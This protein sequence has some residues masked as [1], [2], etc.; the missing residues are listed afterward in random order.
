MEPIRSRGY[1][2]TVGFNP[3]QAP[4]TAEQQ[5]RQD[6]EFIRRFK[7]VKQA[8]LD[9]LA[10]EAADMKFRGQ[11]TLQSLQNA[12]NREAQY[13]AERDALQREKLARQAEFEK[14][15]TGTTSSSSK[16]NDALELVGNLSK[17]AAQTYGKVDQIQTEY[18][19]NEADL[20]YQQAEAYGYK[21]EEVLSY[22]N[23]KVGS[24]AQDNANQLIQLQQESGLRQIEATNPA[25]A[26]K[27][28]KSMGN[29]RIKAELRKAYG[30]RLGKDFSSIVSNQIQE[31]YAR[32]PEKLYSYQGEEVAI[33][34]LNINDP[35]VMDEL[36]ARQVRPYLQGNGLGDVSPQGLG[37]FYKNV[38]ASRSQFIGNMRKAETEAF[39]SEAIDNTRTIFTTEPTPI[40]AQ[41]YYTVQ[42]Q[43]GI[44]PAKARANMLQAAIQ[45]PQDQ[46]ER[47]GDMPFG[48][49]D[50]PLREQYSTDWEAA[51]Q[52]RGTLIEARFNNNQ[53]ARREEELNQLQEYRATKLKDYED[54]SFDA[55][56]E[57]LQEAANNYRIL[58]MEKLAREIENDIPLTAS[59]QYNN[60]FLDNFN[61]EL[62]RGVVPYSAEQI[63]NNPS[64]DRKTKQSALQALKGFAETSVPASVSKED[65]KE[66][67]VALKERAKV[68]EFGGKPANPT[69]NRVKSKA[70]DRYRQVYKQELLR[71][72]DP[73]QARSAALQDF[74]AEFGD[75]PL[76]GKYRVE[77]PTGP[78]ASTKSGE[79]IEG[80]VTGKAYSSDNVI[81]DIQIKMHQN[82]NAL[83]EPELFEGE[84]TLLEG[85]VKGSKMGRVNVPPVYEFMLSRAGG[86]MSMR[87]LLNTRLKANGLDELPKDVNTMAEEVESSFDPR[88]SKFINYKPNFTRTDIA[89]IGSGMD[90]IYQANLPANVKSDVEFQQEVSAVSQRLG[91]QEGDLYA[92]MDFET[93]GSFS[94]SQRNA[95]GS[96]ATG[97]IQ[98]MPSTARG[99]GTTTEAL[100]SMSRTQQMKYVETYLRNAGVKPGMDVSDLYMSVLFPAAVGKPDNFVLFGRGAISGYTGRAYDQNRGLDS[101]GDGSIT[102]AEAAAKVK[103]SANAWR[104]SRNMRPE[105]V[106]GQ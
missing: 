84:S 49:N 41:Q 64:L 62:L 32:D 11:A 9:A 56:P 21:P 8:E 87:A 34:S 33:G 96:G 24:Q 92:I 46:W 22:L 23:E 88:Y 55:N 1:A 80:R 25:F 35:D 29:S 91:I 27:L 13:A 67:E 47:I 104:Q 26:A 76:K 106:G 7:E 19:K 12:G 45:L 98:F 3:R 20:I 66:I 28:R 18:A 51:R 6:E 74:Y 65:F 61:E 79:F 53:N 81:N 54:G 75:D 103:G 101:N 44:A 97:L 39:K 99:L 90:P 58:G 105:L 86:Q 43:N 17:I 69:L 42:T 95:A 77:D 63:I 93:G 71:T 82:P 14:R 16:F 40:N 70:Y 72:N 94:P 83:S 30:G 2:Q 50:K 102:K 48:P 85:V 37:D 68:N 5:R 36:M 15:A 10:A 57:Q 89:A 78:N 4:N 59:K 100:A 38:T 60:K 73:T 31:D 52:Q